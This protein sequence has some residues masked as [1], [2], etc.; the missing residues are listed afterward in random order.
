MQDDHYPLPA[1]AQHAGELHESTFAAAHTAQ[2]ACAGV[3]SATCF[4]ADWKRSGHGHH[5]LPK[6]RSSVICRV[7][8]IVLD[9]TRSLQPNTSS[10]VLA[11]PD[12]MSGSSYQCKQDALPHH[13][14]RKYCS[15]GPH[16]GHAQHWAAPS[17]QRWAAH[18]MEPRA[19][20]YACTSRSTRRAERACTT[21]AL[22]LAMSRFR[23]CC[24]GATYAAPT[25]PP[26][27]PA[28]SR[29]R[30]A[31][32]STC[33]ASPGTKAWLDGWLAPAVDNA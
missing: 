29:S 22:L 12:H 13:N 3:P 28:N 18:R 17:A 6:P 14:G 11:R 25:L 9:F 23:G 26:V 24:G 10:A 16:W 1:R 19:P 32:F 31:G 5:R 15:V 20:G 7:R 4:A 27:R 30:T 8:P 33:G 2:S 21:R